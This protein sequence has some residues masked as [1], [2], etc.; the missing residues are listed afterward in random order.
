MADVIETDAGGQSAA[1]DGG[2]RVLGSIEDQRGMF[3]GAVRVWNGELARGQDR[4][5]AAGGSGVV[6]DPEKIVREPEPL[7]KP[8]EGDLF[9]FRRRGRRLPQHVIDVQRGR[10]HFAQDAGT[11]GGDREVGEKARVV[12]VGDAGDDQVAEVGEDGIHGLALFRA[13]GR[14]AVDERAGLDVGQN[15]KIANVAKVVGDPIYNLVAGGAE[16]VGGH[17]RTHASHVLPIKR[18]CA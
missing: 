1:V 7:A 9:Q 8:A 6:D 3:A 14:Q 15:G 5:Q 10:Q 16:F 18:P 13:C 17:F 4:V 2:M 12:P 11:G